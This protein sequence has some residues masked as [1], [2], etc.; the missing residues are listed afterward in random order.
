VKHLNARAR[1]AYLAEHVVARGCIGRQD[2]PTPQM[3]APAKRA[4]AST[5]WGPD[6][7]EAVQALILHGAKD[8]G[9]ADVGRGAS[10]TTAQAWPLGDPN[11]PGLRR[12]VAPRCGRAWATRKARGVRGVGTALPPV[13]TR[14]RS[15][16]AHQR[17][18]NG[19]AEQR[20]L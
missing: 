9:G 12:G 3:R 17:C 5:A 19:P 18:A 10:D 8:H 14:L 20:Q 2:A 11:E 16:K 1:E 4:R 13:E 15:V 7:I 6:G